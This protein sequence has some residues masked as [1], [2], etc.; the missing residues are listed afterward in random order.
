[1]SSREASPVPTPARVTGPPTIL[2]AHVRT[3]LVEAL[4][5]LLVAVHGEAQGQRAVA[6]AT[7]ASPSG[8]DRGPS[9]RGRSRSLDQPQAADVPTPATSR[10]GGIPRFKIFAAPPVHPHWPKKTR[11]ST[12]KASRT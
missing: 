1:M 4:A 3:D 8:R 2:P 7:D 12:P 9:S 5:D 6:S 10:P 11:A